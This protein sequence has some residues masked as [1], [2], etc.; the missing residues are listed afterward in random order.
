MA[1]NYGKV[2]RNLISKALK[3]AE[4]SKGSPL[5]AKQKSFLRNRWKRKL[6][7]VRRKA[8]RENNL[9]IYRRFVNMR[10]LPKR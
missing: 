6:V 2:E 4:R 10:R 8:I 5:T 7:A 9:D 1:I 3:K